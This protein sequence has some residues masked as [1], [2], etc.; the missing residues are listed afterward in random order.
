[1]KVLLVGAGGRE[2]ALAWRLRQEDPSIQIVAAPGNPGIAELAECLPIGASDVDALVR[3][4]RENAVDWT[5]VGPEAPLAAGIVDA[6][7]AAGRPIFGPTQAAAQ[8][9]TS[10]A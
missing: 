7:R 3:Y 9:E 10:K 5:L 4:A 8:L 6:F 1:M 2:H